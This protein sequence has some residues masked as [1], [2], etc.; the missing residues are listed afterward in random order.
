VNEGRPPSLHKELWFE[1]AKLYKSIQEYDVIRGILA[2]NF[3]TSSPVFKEAIEAEA[4]GD[5]SLACDC[6]DQLHSGSVSDN[7]ELNFVESGLLKSLEMLGKWPNVKTRI[8]ELCGYQ[9]N[10]WKRLWELNVTWHVRM[11]FCFNTWWITD[12]TSTLCPNL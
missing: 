10:F 9:P 4:Q 8:D 11:Y 7:F 6:Y 3:V 2:S 1:L 5:Y 12:R